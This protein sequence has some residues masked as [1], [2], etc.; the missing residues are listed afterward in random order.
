M[1]LHVPPEEAEGFVPF[2]RQAESNRERREFRGAL[3]A[4]DRALEALTGGAF[5]RG[6]ADQLAWTRLARAE[7]AW[8]LG[9]WDQVL[10]DAEAITALDGQL[11]EETG[12]LP[13]VWILASRIH[14]A[15]GHYRKAE[16]LLERA[17]DR[18]AQSPDP[19]ARAQV[20]LE[21]GALH[22][23]I[24]QH[25]AGQAEL[26]EAR[27]LI[28]ERVEEPRAARAVVKLAIEQ[29]LAA[30]RQGRSEEARHFNEH[31]LSVARQHL[32][33]TCQ[34]ADAHR[35]LAIVAS[36]QG[37]YVEALRGYLQSLEIYREQGA[38]LGQAKVYGSIGQALLELSR[39]DEALFALNR[40]RKLAVKL[41]ADTQKAALYGKLGMIYREREE[42]D[43]AVEYHLKDVELARR[44][45][46]ERALGFAFRNL[47]LSYR[48]RGEGDEARSYL[49]ESLERF[50]GLGDHSRV[51]M[52]RLDLAEVWLDL[53]RFMEAEEQ[54][55]AARGLLEQTQSHGE[56][57]RMHL[58]HGVL[59]RELRRTSEAERELTAALQILTSL[60][61]SGMLVE[62]HFELARL[63][64]VMADS[65]RAVGHLKLAQ[66]L[67]RQL[68]LNRLMKSVVGLL[69]QINELELVRLVV[70]EIER[71]QALA[72]LTSAGARPRITDS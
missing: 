59:D 64:Q 19:L 6:G 20:A 16:V 50:E 69:E 71:E 14:V 10:E 42:F 3:A 38:L 34:E 18:L 25:A 26:E 46:N 9:R 56:L 62:I 65:H 4:W 23:K 41:G 12:C 29:G 44:F 47:G 58:L 45:G 53:G 54:L 40:A 11:Q 48:A 36:V 55:E 22:N 2:I 8:Q 57:A 51:A 17:R 21:L 15:N 49:S 70:Q 68:G 43:K 13:R 39:V 63:Y 66:G 1:R 33:R 27:S 52:V 67:A 37:R 24:G 60:Q 7:L 35:F 31:A 61:P 72:R 32:P 5:S 28:G 30:F